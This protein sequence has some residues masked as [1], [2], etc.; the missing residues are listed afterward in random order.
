MTSP[1]TRGDGAGAAEDQP[2]EAV[3]RVMQQ[4]IEERRD[5][6]RV[7]EEIAPIF[8]RTVRR[9]QR[10]PPFVAAH[11]QLEEIFGRRCVI[12]RMTRSSVMNS[13]TVASCER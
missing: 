9:R 13:D 5:G 2:F 7:S 10:R 6:G 8:H 3:V 11:H 4:A 12:F 1:Y